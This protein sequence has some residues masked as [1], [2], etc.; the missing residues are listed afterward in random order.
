MNGRFVAGWRLHDMMTP[1]IGDPPTI[2]TAKGAK[3]VWP[4]LLMVSLTQLNA[5]LIFC[6]QE[7][8]G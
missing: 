4:D 7:D 5:A 3:N 2:E 1:G 6:P 8:H